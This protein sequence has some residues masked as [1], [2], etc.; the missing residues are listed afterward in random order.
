MYLNKEG[1]NTVEIDINC[2]AGNLKLRYALS[3]NP[4]QYVWQKIHAKTVTYRTAIPMNISK[5][6]ALNIA[7]K[8][9]D[10][11]NFE[12]IPYDFTQ[13]DL[14]RAHQ[15]VVEKSTI[16][17]DT[18][19]VVLNNIIHVLEQK[20]KNKFVNYN[21][22]ISFYSLN[23]ETY[24]PVEEHFKLWLDAN[25]KWGDLFMGYGTLG[26]DWLDIR[27]DNDDLKE[28]ALQKY[29]SSETC[30]CFRTEYNY[31][32]AEET[33]LYRWSKDFDINVPVDNLNLLS[34]GRYFLGRII[35]DDQFLQFH[36]STS[37]WYVPN[38]KCKLLWNRD[39]I[40]DNVKINAIRFYDSDDYFKTLDD[41]SMIR[42][43]L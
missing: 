6:S 34:L 9:C 27:A 29:I 3:D 24:V 1:F 36:N 35:I 19:L 43:L 40:G 21:A 15:T 42:D 23:N 41:H 22:T 31:P 33:L 2:R 18:D 37:D 32:K 30:M 12:K 16:K 14:N 4:V 28:L 38:H 25:P 10:N 13:D 26:K 7:N 39:V 8:I 5:E 20:I 17:T 11:M